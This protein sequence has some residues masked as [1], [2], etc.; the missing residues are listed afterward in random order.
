MGTTTAEKLYKRAHELAEVDFED[1]IDCENCQMNISMFREMISKRELFYKA[2]HW[3][4]ERYENWEEFLE[5]AEK[6]MSDWNL[7]SNLGCIFVM[8][9]YE[10]SKTMQ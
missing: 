10:S 1:E 6:E 3:A 9:M 2:I 7:A 8:W 5:D 4:S